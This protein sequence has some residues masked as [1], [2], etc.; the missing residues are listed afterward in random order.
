MSSLPASMRWIGSKTTEKRWKH[1]F[2]HYKSMGAIC[3]HGNQSFDPICPKTLCTLF[4][5]PKM[6]HIKF[7]QGC[8]TGFKDIQLQNYEIFV[9]QGQVTP[10]WVVRFGPK[11]KLD[12]AFMP[13]LVISNFDDDSIKHERAS[14]ETPFSHYKSM[15]NIF[16]APGQ[17][18]A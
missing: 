14:I 15:G 7:D 8:P 13:V 1:S 10:N 2:Y 4:L 5:T 12:P 16:D 3:C 6:L 17:L 9:T 18:T 11:S